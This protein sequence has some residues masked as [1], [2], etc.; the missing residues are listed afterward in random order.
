MQ[1]VI[2]THIIHISDVH[3]RKGDK[4]YGEYKKVVAN[5]DSFLE[6]QPF[7]RTKSALIVITG[8]VFHDKGS[9]DVYGI[10]LFTDLCKALADRAPTVIIAGN[11]D[12]KQD[13]TTLS[14]HLPA[15]IIKVLTATIDHP[16]LHYVGAS[17]IHEF[18]NVG[19]GVQDIRDVLE[20]G[21][22]TGLS[23]SMNPFP[24]PKPFSSH[25]G[26]KVALCH[27]AIDE[28]CGGFRH[29]SL[30]SHRHFEG[31]DCVLLGD[32]HKRRLQIEGK[33][34][35]GY[36]GSLIQQNFGEERMHGG[37]IWDLNNRQVT[38]FD[39][40]NSFMYLTITEDRHYP[41]RLVIN[42]TKRELSAKS[43][44]EATEGATYLHIRTKGCNLTRERRMYIEDVCKSADRV[45]ESWIDH[46]VDSSHDKYMHEDIHEECGE[47]DS[48]DTWI[49][50][51]TSVL[52][53]KEC[54][55]D[56][57]SFIR[58]H[59]NFLPCLDDISTYVPEAKKM[60]LIQ[61]Y[62]QLK[63]TN[64]DEMKE[65]I[66]HRYA[67]QK[68]S[69]RELSWEW[70][71]SFG[72]NNACD[73]TDMKQRVVLLN[74]KNAS[75]KSNFIEIILLAMFGQGIPSRA[76]CHYTSHCIL[77][78]QK[79]K[80]A[81][82]NTRI[83]FRLGKDDYTLIRKYKPQTKTTSLNIE[84]VLES[85]HFAHP[86]KQGAVK[87]WLKE[88]VATPQ[89][90]L[91]SCI[92]TQNNDHDYF[93][94]KDVDRTDILQRSLD[95]SS[96]QAMTTIIK[97]TQSLYKQLNTMI[98]TSLSNFEQQ[99]ND[100]A[101]SNATQENI[102]NLQI[103]ITDTISKIYET[104]AI[105][106]KHQSHFD[107]KKKDVLKQY[108]L[109]ETPTT[110]SDDEMQTLQSKIAELKCIYR[111]YPV[112]VP[113][114][115][116][117]PPTTDENEITPPD[118]TLDHF[119]SLEKKWNRLNQDEIKQSMQRYMQ[120]PLHEEEQLMLHIQECER[121]IS[122][123]MSNRPMSR[124][125]TPKEY[126]RLYSNL[127][128]YEEELP[129]WKQ[130]LVKQKEIEEAH[131]I[132]K[133][134]DQLSQQLFKLQYD[135]VSL[136]PECWACKLNPVYVQR[137]IITNHLEIFR[138]KQRLVL[139]DL[140]LLRSYADFQKWNRSFGEAIKY[141]TWIREEHEII[142]NNV[143]WEADHDRLK[144]ELQT[145]KAHLTKMETRALCRE[146][147]EKQNQLYSYIKHADAQ[148]A[149]L[150][151]TYDEAMLTKA[152]PHY[153]A[154]V[155]A[156]NEYDA[157]TKERIRLEKQLALALH[158]RSALG[159]LQTRIEKAK[160]AL[161]L[162]ARHYDL[163]IMLSKHF[164]GDKD[165]NGLKEWMQREK[166]I[167]FLVSKINPILCHYGL[168]I[169]VCYEQQRYDF[170][171]K[172]NTTHTTIIYE[173]AS[174]F[175]KFLVGLAMRSAISRIGTNKILQSQN[176]STKASQHATKTTCKTCRI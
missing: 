91:A 31:Y 23:Q 7:V 102:E 45:V 156:K 80:N 101:Q 17:G 96:V 105:M 166:I 37:L 83:V 167:P 98:E 10:A 126:E 174:G 170:Y 104:E 154:F 56:A 21:N 52:T 113:A 161:E 164:E 123:L 151:N 50:Y 41:D 18:G 2:Y 139:D 133:D 143:S 11:H 48:K 79:P 142:E 9:T 120:E 86:L 24:S 128:K 148:L 75:G 12:I 71:F 25:V 158:A 36:A 118:F 22:T 40:P 53:Q 6:S 163:V 57:I 46:S 55:G 3:I 171:L 26:H 33:L 110:L 64:I 44:V 116:S 32:V 129:L 90:F 63:A 162:Y 59:T 106:T 111:M 62:E 119:K 155:K 94:M 30:I 121:K 74:G 68:F 4:R 147:E 135:D 29:E 145:S 169:L 117:I 42:D 165:T 34:T 65:K 28:V 168:E 130:H 173:R 84:T 150:Q 20:M 85:P 103:I 97:E 5:L 76:N 14:H 112:S 149:I 114:Q 160:T 47:M 35:W 19:I 153:D 77:H 88:N 67:K 82:A 61:K 69:F 49:Q 144:K 107:S 99:Y 100:L 134:I 39:I 8:D 81:V 132:Q 54:L 131:D 159:D 175:Q 66:Q 72:S 152:K 27:V 115:F 73:F 1:S 70:L 93:T 172:D 15:D 87:N 60:T 125:F 136:N 95:M 127:Q 122:H 138:A 51:L 92:F 58:D 38:P 109:S 13:A 108:E 140:E 43:L 78:H 146:Y 89:E 16:N 176:S 141:E 124:R 137:Q 157:M